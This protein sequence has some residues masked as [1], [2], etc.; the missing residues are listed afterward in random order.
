MILA[1]VCYPLFRP[2][3]FSSLKYFEIIWVS[4]LSTLSVPEESYSRN[5]SCALNLISTFFFKLISW[6]SQKR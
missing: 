1:D 3:G 6:Q 4:D 2:F 5:A